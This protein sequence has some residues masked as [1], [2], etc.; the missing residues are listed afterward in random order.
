MYTQVGEENERQIQLK[1]LSAE[2]KQRVMD[3]KTPSSSADK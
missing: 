3:K 1:H 2:N